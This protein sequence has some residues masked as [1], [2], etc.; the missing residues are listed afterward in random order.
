M[1]RHTGMA[2][3]GLLYDYLPCPADSGNCSTVAS[4]LQL[5]QMGDLPDLC[6]LASLGNL[7]GDILSWMDA[8]N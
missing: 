1:V 4:G 3:C 2:I 6:R 5:L 8:K 7:Y